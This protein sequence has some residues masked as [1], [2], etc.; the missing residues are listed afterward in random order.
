L[1]GAAEGEVEKKRD[2]AEG[3][4]V[5]IGTGEERDVGRDAELVEETGKR[6]DCGEEKG[7]DGE[8]E[9]DAIDEGMEAVFRATGAEGLGDQ[10]VEAN[11]ETFAKEGEDEEQA[12]A[13]ADGGYG[14]SAVG[15]AANHHGVHDG[16][17]DPADFGQN[18]RQGQVESGAKLG[19]K[20]GPEEHG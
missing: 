3:Q 11:E 2:Q 1:E 7:R 4:R 15:E 14:L 20:G 6:P 12:G 19:A 13:D 5:H 9:I 17:A 10:G 18:E 16:H 8:A